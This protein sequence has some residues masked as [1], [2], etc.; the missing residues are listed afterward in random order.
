M[1]HAQHQLRHPGERG[2]EYLTSLIGNPAIWVNKW[3]QAN[4]KLI[5]S[6]RAARG[7]M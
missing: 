4:L 1:N 5:A 2:F 3:L 7:Q 6:V